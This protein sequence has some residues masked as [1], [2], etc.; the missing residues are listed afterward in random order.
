MSSGHDGQVSDLHVRVPAVAGRLTGL[1]HALAEWAK[2]A[3]LDEA[4]R[5]A[6]TLATYEAMANTVE[7]AYAGQAQGMLDLSA[8]RDPARGLVIVTVTDHGR[9]RPQPADPGARGRGIPLIRGLTPS[10]VITTSTGGTTVS[11]SW[12]L[13]TEADRPHATPSRRRTR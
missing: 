3:G 7:H 5:E 6:L 2:R 13:R 10:A 1:R 8:V 4:D 9:W 11:M 12:P